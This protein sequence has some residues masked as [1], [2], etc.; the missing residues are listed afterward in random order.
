MSLENK[1]EMQLQ[2]GNQDKPMLSGTLSFINEHCYKFGF[3]ISSITLAISFGFIEELIHLENAK[4]KEHL[5]YAWCFLS[6]AFFLSLLNI[7]I[8]GLARRLSIK[9]RR[10]K[11][12]DR[13]MKW[14]NRII[15]IL[16]VLMIVGLLIGFV[17]LIDFIIKQNT[18]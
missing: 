13:E 3:L 12:M 17:L 8:Y 4:S 15:R 7:F 5:I 2:P 11:K 9:D 6:I 10:A 1:S 16:N 18:F 14:W